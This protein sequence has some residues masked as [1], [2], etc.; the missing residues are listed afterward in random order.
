MMFRRLKNQRG[1]TLVELMVVVAIIAIIAAIAITLYQDVQKKAR[2]AAD[3]GTIAALR[4]A[5]A[6]YYGKNDGTFA[7]QATLGTLVQPSPPV[8]QCPG[9]SWTVD[10][11]NGKISYTPNDI[12]AC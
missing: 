8:L 2:L 7:T 5:G 12:S 4:S 11:L 3:Q 1:V 6:I 9:A 10:V